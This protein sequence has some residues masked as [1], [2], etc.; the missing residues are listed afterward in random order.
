MNSIKIESAQIYLLF[1]DYKHYNENMMGILKKI[2]GKKV[3]YVS[4]W[5]PKDSPQNP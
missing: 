4:F 1:L 2:N 3:A 5:T